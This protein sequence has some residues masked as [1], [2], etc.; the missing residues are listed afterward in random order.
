[1]SYDYHAEAITT[2]QAISEMLSAYLRCRESDNAEWAGRWDA[3]LSRIERE[4]LPSGAGIDIGTVI[5]RDAVTASEAGSRFRLHGSYHAMDSSGMYAGWFDYA[6]DVVATFSGPVVELE[7]LTDG[8]K[9]PEELSEADYPAP[10]RDCPVCDGTGHNQHGD[11]DDC[12]ECDGTGETEDS[13][14]EWY[15]ISDPSDWLIDVYS[16]AVRELT[17][18]GEWEPEP[19]LA[20]A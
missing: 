17:T 5:T 6:I 19:E 9:N 14:A 13:D 4:S 2:A 16:E 8:G 10:T 1:M 7:W 20:S 12:P 15:G 18:R 11:T 3:G